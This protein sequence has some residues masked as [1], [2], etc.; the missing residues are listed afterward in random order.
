MALKNLSLNGLDVPN[1]LRIG[2]Q[3]FLST[4]LTSPTCFSAQPL[5]YRQGISA[6]SRTSGALVIAEWTQTQKY[7]KGL[8]MHLISS[9]AL[10][11]KSIRVVFQTPGLCAGYRLSPKSPE[12]IKMIP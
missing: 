4:V 2:T 3:T 9:F 7:L 5:L 6:A 12:H 1:G 8:A 10:P 11:L